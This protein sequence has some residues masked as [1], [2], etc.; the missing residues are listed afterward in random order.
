[1]RKHLL[2]TTGALMLAVLLHAPRVSSAQE[3]DA[4][5]ANADLDFV[6]KD[7]NGQDV[8]L[9][10][11]KG[12][13]I[14][15]DFWATWCA[16]CRIEIPNFVELYDE[17]GPDG[18]VVLGISVDDAG[19]DLKP[20]ADELAMDYPVLIGAEREDVI[21]AYG[22]PIGYPTTFVIGRDGKICAS[23]T[24]FATKEQFENEILLV[25]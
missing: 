8:A 19:T 23:H 25:L 22:P 17:Y 5:A 12:Q 4:D 21:N 7:I 16:P 24:G 11:F 6:L 3:C 20:F 2:A 9:N 15:L 18:F 10:D 13:V 1:M 14:L